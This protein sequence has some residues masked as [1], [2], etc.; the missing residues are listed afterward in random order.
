MSGAM[1]KYSK[2]LWN[3]C[4]TVILLLLYEDP[5][6]RMCSPKG[7]VLTLCSSIGSSEDTIERRGA[8]ERLAPVTNGDDLRYHKIVLLY[9]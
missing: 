5:Q 1:K 2:K 8:T 7:M 6:I 3:K 4:H 9:R